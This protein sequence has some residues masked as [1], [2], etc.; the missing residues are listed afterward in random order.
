MSR[1][2]APAPAP[3]RNPLRGATVTP[4]RIDQGV[5]YSG[6]GPVH[7]LG[8]GQIL[9]VLNAGWPGGTFIAEQLAAGPH[10]GDIVFVAEDVTPA[11]HIGQHV[12][13][14]TILGEL[15]GQMET[16][17]A[18][19]PP[20]LGETLAMVTGQASATGDP[21]SHPTAWGQDYSRLL[22]SLG[23]PP[24]LLAGRPAGSPAPGT[25][26]GSAGS[27]TGL[28]NLAVIIPI[29]AAGAAIGIWGA[30][31]ATGTDKYLRKAGATAGK[32]TALAAA[33]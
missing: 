33:L 26:A 29:V 12:T 15:H 11:V 28:K 16:G 2:A 31:R 24:G 23:A 32:T 22:A 13:S 8:R 27:L 30:A 17:W 6:Y 19:P 1:P 7:A 21:G 4:G 10:A 14:R 3:Y 5:D 18:A 20:D 9:E 25:P